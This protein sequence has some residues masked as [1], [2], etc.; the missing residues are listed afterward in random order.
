MNRVNAFVWLTA[1][2]IFLSGC[3]GEGIGANSPPTKAAP[4]VSGVLGDGTAQSAASKGEEPK[5]PW[6]WESEPKRILEAFADFL[7]LNLKGSERLDT[8]TLSAQR[9][10]ELMPRTKVSRKYLD[11]I[12]NPP[13]DFPPIMVGGDHVSVE[14]SDCTIRTVGGRTRLFQMTW[15]MN[16]IVEKGTADS[17]APED[18][19]RWPITRN[20]EEVTFKSFN[21][22]SAPAATAAAKMA[23]VPWR[24]RGSLFSN[25]SISQSNDGNVTFSTGGPGAFPRNLGVLIEF[26]QPPSRE[27]LANFVITIDGRTTG[28][29]AWAQKTDEGQ[30]VY[31]SRD[32]GWPLG[33]EFILSGNGHKQASKTPPVVR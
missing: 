11:F 8:A 25:A 20:G 26:A 1:A 6:R 22:Q 18:I 12:R 3:S 13:S 15:D 4:A 23:T 10:T 19:G 5:K 21:D 29:L 31:F 33:K 14:R 17:K 32:G 2:A 28:E 24:I 30:I 7:N 16:V 27:Y 9:T